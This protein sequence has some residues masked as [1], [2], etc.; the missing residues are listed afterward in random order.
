MKAFIRHHNSKTVES[1]E[2]DNYDALLVITNKMRTNKFLSDLG[3]VADFY[4]S[5]EMDNYVAPL[6]ATFNGDIRTKPKTFKTSLPYLPVR[7]S[8]ATKAPKATNGCQM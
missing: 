6:V 7:K 1:L 2:M 3:Q 8:E 5:P 4:E